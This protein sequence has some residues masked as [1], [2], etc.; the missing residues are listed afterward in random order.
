M[1]WPDLESGRDGREQERPEEGRNTSTLSRD[2][3]PPHSRIPSSAGALV[4]VV[5]LVV[6]FVVVVVVVVVVVDN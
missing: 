2:P 5:G 3:S 6:G 1:V 4:V